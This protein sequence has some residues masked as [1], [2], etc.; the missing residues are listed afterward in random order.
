MG[1]KAK[2]VDQFLVTEALCSVRVGLRHLLLRLLAQCILSCLLGELV[3]GT[4]N[5]GHAEGY[6]EFC[7]LDTK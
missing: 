1:A 4:S 2:C 7:T 5:T 6:F 3:E